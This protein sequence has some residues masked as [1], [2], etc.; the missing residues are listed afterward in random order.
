M[1]YAVCAVFPAR[2][3]DDGVENTAGSD[4]EAMQQS[5]TGKEDSGRHAVHAGHVWI[6]C[7]NPAAGMLLLWAYTPT[8]VSAGY[9]Y[10]L[11]LCE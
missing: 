2:Q 3:T 1:T 9:S 10:W 11:S 8:P 5:C 6:T 4:R 7:G